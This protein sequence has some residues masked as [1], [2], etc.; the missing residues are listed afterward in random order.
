M[1][2]Q[3]VTAERAVLWNPAA[4]MPV[5]WTVQVRAQAHAE[6]DLLVLEVEIRTLA[7]RRIEY[8][9]LVFEGCAAFKQ[10]PV[11]SPGNLRLTRRD[12]SR[13]LA[14]QPNALWVI[15]GSEWLPTCGAG[16]LEPG[17][18]Q[19]YVVYEVTRFRVWHIAAMRCSAKRLEAE[20]PVQ[21][22]DNQEAALALVAVSERR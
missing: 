21:P 10:E 12:W 14:P 15:E 13:P 18:L 3:R 17:S 4:E 22:L 19:H 6:I 9:R 11:G 2:P 16:E 20:Q 5:P 8:W 1:T 7:E